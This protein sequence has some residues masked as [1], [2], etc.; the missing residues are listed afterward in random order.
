MSESTPNDR[1]ATAPDPDAREAE[2][3]ETEETRFERL[4]ERER[5]DRDQTAA[6]LREELDDGGEEQPSPPH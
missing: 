6:R 1:P 4:A 2:S 3:A 5:A